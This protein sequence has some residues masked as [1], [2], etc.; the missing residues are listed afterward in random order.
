MLS[1]NDPNLE[2][3]IEE[4]FSYENKICYEWNEILNHKKHKNNFCVLFI[5]MHEFIN[6][7]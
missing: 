5:N 4:E 6:A 2:K 3:T 7:I 1:W